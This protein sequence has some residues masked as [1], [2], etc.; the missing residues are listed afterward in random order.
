[1]PECHEYTR[2]EFLRF[3]KSR[4][5]GNYE[6][7]VLSLQLGQWNGT[8]GFGWVS[9][10]CKYSHLRGN[11]IRMPGTFPRRVSL[12]ELFDTH[13]TQSNNPRENYDIYC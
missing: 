12:Q 3:L 4:R 13:P 11:V 1:M 7:E 9:L 6:A 2:R 8:D 5:Q 10:P